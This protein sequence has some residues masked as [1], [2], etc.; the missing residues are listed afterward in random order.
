[1]MRNSILY[2]YFIDLFLGKIKFSNSAAFCHL[3]SSS[4]FRAGKQGVKTSEMR[5]SHEVPKS[6][7]ITLC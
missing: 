7:E 5:A 2:R 1:M 3:S 4:L 6:G